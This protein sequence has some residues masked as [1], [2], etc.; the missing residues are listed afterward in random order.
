MATAEENLQREIQAVS[1]MIS[2]VG[3]ST[4]NLGRTLASLNQQMTALRSGTSIAI[5]GLSAFGKSTGSATEQASKLAS[6]LGSAG[7]ETERLSRRQAAVSQMSKQVADEMRALQASFTA[8]AITEREYAEAKEAGIRAIREAA[9]SDREA[10]A[11]AEQAARAGVKQAEGMARVTQITEQFGKVAKYAS[12]AFNIAGTAAS[13][14]YQGA[15]NRDPFAGIQRQIEA[16]TGGIVSALKMAGAGATVF[17]EVARHPAAR[18]GLEALAGVLGSAAK[19]LENITKVG[20]ILTQSIGDFVKEYSRAN[21]LGMAFADGMN[22]LRDAAGGAKVNMD[23]LVDGIARGEQ[24]FRSAGLSTT[25]AANALKFF[26]KG[27]NEGKDAL[28]LFGMGF[29]D[30]AERIALAASAMDR[31]RASG[32]SMAETQQNLVSITTQYAKDLKVMQAVVGKNAEAEM[33]KGR[34]LAAQTALQSKLDVDQRK[35][36]ADVFTVM[37]KLGPEA[38]KFQTAIAQRAAGGAVTDASIAADPVLMELI[39]KQVGIIMSGSKTATEE[40]GKALQQSANRA[41]D[42]AQRG[43]Q[44]QK[45]AEAALFGGDNATALL[46]NNRRINDQL[47]QMRDNVN[48]GEQARLQA[49]GSNARGQAGYN[50]GRPLDSNGQPIG[51]APNETAAAA[52]VALRQ[53]QQRVML[54]QAMTQTEIV[55]NFAEVMKV[56]M[57]PTNGMID[58]IKRF[59]ASA[60]ETSQVLATALRTSQGGDGAPAGAPGITDTLLSKLEGVFTPFLAGLRDFGNKLGQFFTGSTI[61]QFAAGGIVQGSPG[62]FLSM[63][64]GNEAVIP[65]PDNVRG[66]EFAKALQNLLVQDQQTDT[67]VPDFMSSR[68]FSNIL[69]RATEAMSTKNALKTSD[70]SGTD[71]ILTINNRINDML[72]MMKDNAS[73]IEKS[74]SEASAVPSA[75][76]IRMNVPGITDIANSIEE[77]NRAKAEEQRVAAAQAELTSARPGVSRGLNDMA[78]TNQTMTK[79]EELMERI[80][81]QISIMNSR[82]EESMRSLRSIENHT[83][84]TARGVA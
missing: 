76:E 8:G 53:N 52:E 71:D 59:G 41:Q 13:G 70:I 61:P 27:L 4:G 72:K 83:D 12:Q 28:G 3:D 24:A 47:M 37:S 81:D 18:L 11:A 30:P 49:D 50:D 82:M 31:A 16:S 36:A 51:P 64:H 29:T 67:K 5:A 78:M 60:A 63:L 74:I 21:Q 65:L 19:A 9:G 20:G 55:R 79:Q 46:Q 7:T 32:L 39:D 62:G 84:R 68:D 10:A 43:G 58:L 80:G 48:T 26:G 1:E 35:A 40:S 77:Q 25:Q 2:R 22:G 17:A 54:E 69:D 75:N 23:V 15:G 33:A 38:A 34:A 73:N 42:E 56:A 57:E 6:R 45:I 14:M 44:N 66:P